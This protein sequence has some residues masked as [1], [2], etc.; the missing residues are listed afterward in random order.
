M[1]IAE[2]SGQ[3][4]ATGSHGSVS[5]DR[6]EAFLRSKQNLIVAA[7]CACAFLRILIFC[8]G[9]PLFNTL[10]EQDH[11]ETV[12]NYSRGMVPGKASPLSDPDMARVFALYG[13][14][15]YLISRQ[16]LHAVG[17]DVPVP[18]LAPQVRELQFERRFN[19]WLTQPVTEAQ[20]PPVYY[21][22]AGVWYKLGALLGI[23]DW[24]LA[25]WVRFLNAILYG[26]FI[27]IAFLFVREVYQQN[28]FLCVAVPGLLAVFPQ[29]VFFGVN[30]DILSPLLVTVA[31]LL[32]FRA[33]EKE[34]D[35]R[36]ELAAG[37]A[38]TGLAFLTDVSNFV[39]F[40]VFMAV[41][42]ILARKNIQ[43]EKVRRDFW[44]IGLGAMAAALPPVLWMARNRAVTGDLTGSKA[45]IAYLGWTV[46]PWGD[47]WQHPIFTLHGA[48]YFLREMIL[49]YWR[50]ELVWQGTPMRSA[51]M[52]G[53]YLIS[54]CLLI[55]AFAAHVVG[56]NEAEEHAPRERGLRVN[57]LV[58]LYLLAVSILFL[59]AISLPFDFHECVYPSRQNPYFLSGRIICGTL[60]PFAVIYAG[61]FEFLWRPLRRY[62]HPVIPFAVICVLI[63]G[64]EMLLRADVFH[65]AFNFFSLSGR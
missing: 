19:Y 23:K 10:D 52:D 30:R 5:N 11:L 60:L 49:K 27:W 9:F 2:Q 51:I 35:W 31:L 3:S 24:A 21:A 4:P 6:I 43:H 42:Y 45:K 8:A 47:F 54:T 15:E 39:L 16:R 41:L 58:S 13:S 53:F 61:G 65:S 48:G 29:D 32:L 38:V 1:N 33:M 44:T 50:G 62:V 36:L 55:T 14:P 59:G 57:G 17:M 37:G 25:Y 7:I 56:R 12:R 64:S 28:T 46:K 18:E 20:S 26:V 34:K 63:T 22:V 40:G